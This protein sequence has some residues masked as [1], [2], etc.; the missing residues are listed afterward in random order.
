M[1][2]WSV[3]D[4]TTEDR[5]WVVKL[6]TANKGCLGNVASSVWW[7]Y[8]QARAAATRKAPCRERWIVIRPYAFAHYRLRKDGVRT[9]YEIATSAEMKRRGLATALIGAMGAPVVLKTDAD[10]AESNALY[11]ALGFVLMATV[12]NGAR[13]FNYYQR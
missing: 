4:A 6:F 13:Q 11:K 8:W 7:R 2:L 12:E 5:D 3:E 9:L 1:S 10:N